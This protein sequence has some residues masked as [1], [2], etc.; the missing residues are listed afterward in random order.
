MIWGHKGIAEGIH[1]EV[2]LENKTDL[3]HME[4]LSP[5]FRFIVTLTR[6]QFAWPGDLSPGIY[7][8]EN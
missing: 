8:T 3:H 5:P 2:P 4:V 7:V 6:V 1:F